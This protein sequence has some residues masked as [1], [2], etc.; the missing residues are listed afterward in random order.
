M[1][2]PPAKGQ[3]KRGPGVRTKVLPTGIGNCP[4]IDITVGQEQ[5]HALGWGEQ[6]LHGRRK[7]GPQKVRIAAR[8]R[9]ET[10]M[11]LEWVANRLCMGAPTLS[12]SGICGCAELRLL[13]DNGPDFPAVADEEEAAQAEQT[14]RG[15][16]GNGCG[17][18]G[19]LRQV[20]ALPIQGDEPLLEVQRP[21]TGPTT[22]WIIG[23]LPA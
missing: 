1:L 9:Q 3:P 23:V 20:P 13:A 18:Y 14:Q 7:S 6:D 10:T 12:L 15:R 8:L 2:G 19:K 16:F 11:T 17:V 4:S 5:Q 21:Y 22:T